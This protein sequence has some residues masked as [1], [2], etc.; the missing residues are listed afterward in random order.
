MNESLLAGLGLVMQIAEIVC[1][2]I[3]L[4]LPWMILSAIKSVRASIEA[5]SANRTHEIKAVMN[6]MR[7]LH[8][9]LLSLCGREDEIE[10]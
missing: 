10:P 1:D 7:Q 4:L 3:I 8:E 5:A 6:A 2:I 9:D